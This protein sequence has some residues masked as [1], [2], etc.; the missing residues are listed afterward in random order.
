MNLMTEQK[1]ERF[2]N[3]PNSFSLIR[4]FLIPLFLYAMIQHNALHALVVFLLASTTDILD[5]LTA[6]IYHQKTKIGALLD[7]AAD[8]LLMTA[9]V[10][11]LSIPSISQPNAL[12]LWLAVAI[13]GRDIVIVSAA[14]VMYMWKGHSKF[15]PSL[16]GKASTVCQMGVILCVLLLNV[17]SRTSTLLLWLYVITFIL[18]ILSGIGYGLSGMRSLK[19]SYR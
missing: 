8:K 10:I 2:W 11:I 12:P 1:K 15:P 7:P 4:I 5:G 13:I 14:L 16:L 17:W 9:A 6:R 19:D 3:I 18:T